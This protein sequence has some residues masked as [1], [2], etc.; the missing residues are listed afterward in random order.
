MLNRFVMGV[1][2]NKFLH[3]AQFISKTKNNT[4]VTAFVDNNAVNQFN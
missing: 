2:F 3:P 4:D 1:S